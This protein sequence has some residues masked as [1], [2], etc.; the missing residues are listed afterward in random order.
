[1][2]HHK[3]ISENSLTRLSLTHQIQSISR[4]CWFTLEWYPQSFHHLPQSHC[5]EAI[6][7]GLFQQ[8]LYRSTYFCSRLSLFHSNQN[9]SFKMIVRLCHFSAQNLP[10]AFIC[11]KNKIESFPFPRPLHLTPGCLPG[12]ISYNPLLLT[13]LQPCLLPG[14]SQDTRFLFYPLDLGNAIL[15]ETLFSQTMAWLFLSIPL[16]FCFHVTLS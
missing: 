15:P 2:L 8:P 10:M 16:G 5:I 7:F 6:S 13:L 9:N 3:V 1:M 11:T 14:C 12:P 4:D